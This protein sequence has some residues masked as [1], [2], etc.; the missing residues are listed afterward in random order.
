MK[1]PVFYWIIYAV[2]NLTLSFVLA[3]KNAYQ[4]GYSIGTAIGYTVLLLAILAIIQF[5]MYLFRMSVKQSVMR[6]L[7]IIFGSLLSVSL[8]GVRGNTFQYNNEMAQLQKCVK[9]FEE[10]SLE[11]PALNQYDFND[12][13]QCA[14]EKM[15]GVPLEDSAK[16]Q[17]ARSTPYLDLLGP[18]WQ[19]ALIQKK[20]IGVDAGMLPDTVPVINLHNFIRVKVKLNGKEIY[21]IF[22]S[23][24]SDVLISKDVIQDQIDNGTVVL[25][26]EEN[27]Y[28]LADG[29]VIT[30]EMGTANEL[31][32]GDFTLQDIDLAII[33]DGG[34][35]LL[36][37]SVLDQFTSWT[38]NSD[39]QL[40]LVP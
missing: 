34:S 31:T 7:F 29:S 33:A 35:P 28:E 26:D 10:M 21:M 4:I 38:I 19:S 12:Y 17:D 22:D 2:I 8:I 3:E 32:I 40:I 24:A 25:K 18:C 30:A 14:L 36:G 15:K 1:V 9:E 6:V 39:N 13:C 27:E 5:F 11:K 20:V 23:G 16:Y 37:K